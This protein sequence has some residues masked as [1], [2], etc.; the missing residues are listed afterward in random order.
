MS[1][2]STNN[3]L[4]NNEQDIPPMRVPLQPVYVTTN[5]HQ[6]P[7]Q[8]ISARQRSRSADMLSTKDLSIGHTTNLDENEVS[9]L[10]RNHSSEELQQ[11]EPSVFNET[12]FP[13]TTTIIQSLDPNFIRTTE[14]SVNYQTPTQSYAAYSCEYTRPHQNQLITSPQPESLSSPRNLQQ[15]QQP[16]NEIQYSNSSSA[17]S[18]FT[19]VHPLTNNSYS[20]RPLPTPS[21][22]SM[23]T[24][25]NL[26]QT[27]YSDDPM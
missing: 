27:P 12:D 22:N 11:Q 5:N 26:N 4:S 8:P 6:P 20:Q 15:P 9:P 24:S 23:Y 18:A 19:L 25:N 3:I 21:Y 1:E 7:Q 10:Q 14:A 17:A 2:V 16:E 13:V